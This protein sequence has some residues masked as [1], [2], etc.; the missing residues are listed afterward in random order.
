M[1]YIGTKPVDFN[2]VTEAKTFEVTSDLTISDK[3]VHSGDTNTAIR[4]AA[5]DTVTIETGGS[6]RAR[7]ASDGKVGIGITSPEALT[8]IAG[9]TADAD[10]ALGSQCHRS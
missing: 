6:E 2:D 1:S 8:H 7:V 3:I 5:A 9:A 10:G 4:F